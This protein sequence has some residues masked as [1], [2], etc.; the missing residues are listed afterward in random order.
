MLEGTPV[1]LHFRFILGD[2]SNETEGSPQAG[3][4]EV[5]CAIW[6]VIVKLV[7]ES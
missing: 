1:S 3:E 7:K 2:R 6:L 4:T 5:S